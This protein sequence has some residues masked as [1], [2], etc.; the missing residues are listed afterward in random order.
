M[1]KVGAEIVYSTCTLTIEENES[2]VNKVIQNYPV[3][4]IEF[5]LN[6]P[7]KNGYNKIGGFTFDCN[8]ER[9]KRIIPWDIKSEGFF[10]AK[11]RKTGS[12]PTSVPIS[13]SIPVGKGLIDADDRSIKEYIKQ[14]SEYYDINFI[15]FKNYKIKMRMF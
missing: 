6:L 10:I 12:I 15:L 7:H 3:E 14:I 1:A 13:K 4:L 2:I 11:L 5:D 8:L 9:T